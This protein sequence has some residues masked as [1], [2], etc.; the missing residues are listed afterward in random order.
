MSVC[1]HYMEHIAMCSGINSSD[2]TFG[3]NCNPWPHRWYVFS[4]LSTENPLMLDYENH[5]ENSCFMPSL[6]TWN[7][8]RG[9]RRFNRLLLFFRDLR[10]TLFKLQ[11]NSISVFRGSEQVCGLRFSMVVCEIKL[12]IVTERNNNE[13]KKKKK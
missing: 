11:Q 5:L 4:D 12:Y 3:I 7:A 9:K 1:R 6:C 13:V 2:Y 8:E 10:I